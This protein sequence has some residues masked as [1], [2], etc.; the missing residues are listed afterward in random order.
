MTTAAELEKVSNTIRPKRFRVEDF[1]KMTEAGIL[2]EESGWE[3]IDGY[4][5]DKM[6]IGSKHASVVR[7]LEKFFERAVGDRFIVSGQNP[8][9]IDDYNAPEPDV[10]LLAPREDFYSE[11]HPTP[12]DVLL[13]VEV[14]DSTVE[15]DREIKK[16]LYAEAGIQEFWLVNLK[17]KTVEVYTQPKNGNYYSALI[18]EAGETI[19]SKSIEN[20]QLSIEEILGF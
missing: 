18:L 13:L 4:L 8:I 10:A 17:D 9:Q 11:S 2:T 12:L 7:R 20:L 15:Y 1:R 5:L 6:T 3:I 16:A 14:S 19:E